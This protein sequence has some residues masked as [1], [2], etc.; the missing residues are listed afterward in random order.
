MK[1]QI[2]IFLDKETETAESEFNFDLNLK[3]SSICLDSLSGEVG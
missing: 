1:K 3:I 2:N